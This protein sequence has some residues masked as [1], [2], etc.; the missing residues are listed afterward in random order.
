MSANA[1]YQQLNFQQGGHEPLP[2]FVRG[3]EVRRPE[4][5]PVEDPPEYDEQRLSGARGHPDVAITTDPPDFPQVATTAAIGRTWYRRFR[6]RHGD[7]EEGQGE[8]T[9]DGYQPH[10]SLQQHTPNSHAEHYEKYT[11]SGEIQNPAH[12]YHSSGYHTAG[13][14]N[15]GQEQSLP[16]YDVR[17]G[18]RFW[19][20]NHEPQQNEYSS[21]ADIMG[22]NRAQTLDVASNPHQHLDHAA[23]QRASTIPAMFNAGEYHDS[24]C[25]MMTE[26]H[27]LRTL[28]RLR[29]L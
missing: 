9:D 1:F 23:F 24:E 22:H 19:Q 20:P 12:G 11:W 13:A 4:Q 18:Q 15:Q 27:V 5:P 6:R 21:E 29:L 25:E 10:Q 8:A 16:E 2:H 3:Q 14:Y 26:R 7:T 28:G 17:T